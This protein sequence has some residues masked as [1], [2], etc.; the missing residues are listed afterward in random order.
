MQYYAIYCY[1]ALNG[2]IKADVGGGGGGRFSP[3]FQVV[4]NAVE[5]ARKEKISLLVLIYQIHRH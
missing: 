2:T 4:R 5:L 3:S 1:K